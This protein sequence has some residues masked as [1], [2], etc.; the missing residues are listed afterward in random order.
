[1][2]KLCIFFVW[3]IF[4]I[5][6]ISPNL[7]HFLRL[8]LHFSCFPPGLQLYQIKKETLVQVFFCKIC[9]IFRYTFSIEHL[10]WASCFRTLCETSSN[11]EFFMVYIFPFSDK[12]SE[13]KNRK[14]KKTNKQI[15]H[16]VEM[17]E[18]GYLYE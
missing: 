15:F 6:N 11:V 12:I 17:L 18:N 9:E 10:Q 1:M 14:K 5:W 13:K 2:K 4:L 3:I 16:A 8:H 7:S